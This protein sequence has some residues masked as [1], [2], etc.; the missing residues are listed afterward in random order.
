[1]PSVLYVP[2]CA[3]LLP[4]SRGQVLREHGC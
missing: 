2:N 3:V 1:M 4:A